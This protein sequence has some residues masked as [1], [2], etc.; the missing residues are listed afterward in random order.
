MSLARPVLGGSARERGRRHLRHAQVR[1]V[2]YL[3]SDGRQGGQHIEAEEVQI[4]AM[5]ACK[6]FITLKR[7]IVMSRW[8]VR[9][10]E[11]SEGGGRQK[12]RVSWRDPEEPPQRIQLPRVLHQGGQ[13]PRGIVITSASAAAAAAALG[14]V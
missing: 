11:G 5:S 9:S 8:R 14:G 2:G 13:K 6:V 12:G 4:K 7:C 10:D 3:K 1:C